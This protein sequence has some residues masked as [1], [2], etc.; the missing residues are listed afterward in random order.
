MD[1]NPTTCKEMGCSVANPIPCASL[2]KFA[3]EAAN[4]EVFCG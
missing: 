4:Y 2:F 1:S 3:A